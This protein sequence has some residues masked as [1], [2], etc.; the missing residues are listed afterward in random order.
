MDFHITNACFKLGLS[1]GRGSEDT[2]KDPR[3]YYALYS[4]KQYVKDDASRKMG[5]I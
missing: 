2:G 1:L 5:R 4:S 3:F